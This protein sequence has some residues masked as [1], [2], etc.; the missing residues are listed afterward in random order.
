M[1]QA[2][3]LWL[4]ECSRLAYEDRPTID[5]ALGP[6]GFAPVRFFDLDETQGYLALHTG[7]ENETPMA[8]LAFRGTEQ[9]FEDVLTDI[10][11]VKSKTPDGDYDVHSGFLEA[12]E[13][14]W[15]LVETAL[16]ELPEDCRLYFTGHSL[17]G[18]LA[19][20]A[21]HRRRPSAL[22][23]FGSPRAV[24]AKLARRL[25]KETPSY[26]VVN[27]T[28]IVTQLPLWGYRHVGETVF[29]NDHGELIHPAPRTT[30]ASRFLLLLSVA[31]LLALGVLPP[32]WIKRMFSNHRI[33]EYI[34]KLSPT[35]GE[36]P[37][38]HDEHHGDEQHDVAA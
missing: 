32:S 13:R 38:H 30:M 21:A 8:V 18:A 11:F 2:A 33:R 31:L 12:L 7:G 19:T 5:A 10:S 22:Y 28:D 6:Q 25:G 24:C 36:S 29:L 4:A 27:S 17:G 16:D 14:V 3:A 35:E 26:R 23:T 20:L 1:D 37:K 34:N 15:R 9:N